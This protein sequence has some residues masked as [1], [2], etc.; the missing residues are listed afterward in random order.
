[1]EAPLAMKKKNRR[2]RKSST[3]SQRDRE[4]S[5]R[6]G[7][8]APR[9]DKKPEKDVSYEAYKKAKKQE[10]A[11]LKK[12]AKVKGKKKQEE[13]PTLAK[14]RSDASK[15]SQG[16]IYSGAFSSSSCGGAAQKDGSIC[17]I[18]LIEVR[19]V[20]EKRYRATDVMAI[21]RGF[22]VWGSTGTQKVS[23]SAVAGLDLAKLSTKCAQDCSES[24][25]CTAR[26]YKKLKRSE[27][28]W[29]MRSAKCAQDC[30]GSSI[31]HKDRNKN[32]M[33]GAAPDLRGR[34]CIVS[35]AGTL[36]DS[37]RRSC[38]AGLQ[39]AVTK[40]IGTAARSKA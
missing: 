23:V 32:S 22:Q 6:Q 26:W 37:V 36:A 5:L 17:F 29:K 40:R 3:Q 25:V 11:Q 15:A 14:L 20:K 13:P 4:M 9:T 24:S 30:S 1:M 38:C 28:F 33:F 7:L 21:K 35:I 8:Q 16:I 27:H 31:S 34:V 19:D 18:L 2:A 10:R 39:L 12:A